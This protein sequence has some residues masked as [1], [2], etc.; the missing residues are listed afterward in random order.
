MELWKEGEVEPVAG[1]Q[2]CLL[3]DWIRGQGPCPPASMAL[4][5]SFNVMYYLAVYI[6]K[7]EEL[8]SNI[9]THLIYY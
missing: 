5:L 9:V 2:L 8:Y 7:V 4:S 6:R 3:A 1:T